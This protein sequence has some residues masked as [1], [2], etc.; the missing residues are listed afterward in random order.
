MSR[1]AIALLSALLVLAV[2]PSMAVAAPPINDDYLDGLAINSDGSLLQDHFQ[3]LSKNTDEATVQEDPDLFGDSGGA[4]PEVTL[5]DLGSRQA[6]Y[7]KTVWWIFFPDV[8]GVVRVQASG[9]DAVIGLVPYDRATDE[10]FYDEWFCADDPA[11]TTTETEFFDVQRGRAYT[12]QIGGWGGD[13]GDPGAGPDNAAS[14]DL[15]FFFDFFPDSDGD[16]ILDQDDDCDTTPGL[17]KF[18]GC[19]DADDDGV[20]EPPDACPG[21]K[22]TLANGC[23]PPPPRP[24]ND[25]D[26]VFDDG[27][28][29]CVGEDASARDANRNG[30]LDLQ[31]LNPKW[32]LKP[33]S[34]FVRRNGR[35]VLLG[36][37]IKRFGVTNVPK[38]ARVVVTCTR[39]A[40]RRM[41]KRA[42]S[43]VLFRQLAG[44]KLRAGVKVTIR[45]TAPG[46]V[47]A[48]R[49][50]TIKRNDYATKSRCLTPGSPRLRTSCSALR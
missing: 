6:H 41:S 40:C 29:Q 49:V 33:D 14:G 16:T 35:V 4:F 47:G 25:H 27:P 20:P 11:A 45:V 15:E 23:N 32:I 43:R 7:G 17:D 13:E 37:E 34:F 38:G 19:P 12:V 46:Y 28:D 50:Y 24:D 18:K 22:G 1:P 42:N 9:F 36:I 21:V 3:D 8:D 31:R 26:G 2:A 5:C 10:P 44:D 39:K 30:C 48:A